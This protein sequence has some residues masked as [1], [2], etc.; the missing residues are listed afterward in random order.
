MIPV[1]SARSTCLATAQRATAEAMRIGGE[2]CE[3]CQ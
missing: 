3:A 1:A 2:E